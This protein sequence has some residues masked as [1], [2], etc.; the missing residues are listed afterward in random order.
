MSWSMYCCYFLYATYCLS[1]AQYHHDPQYMSDLLHDHVYPPPYHFHMCWTLNKSEKIYY[2]K[3]AG[4]W[5]LPHK[6]NTSTSTS[7]N[8]TSNTTT[9]DTVDDMYD[10]KIYNQQLQRNHER[11]SSR[12]PLPSSHQY[13][14]KTTRVAVA[15]AKYNKNKSCP[16]YHVYKEFLRKNENM[17]HLIK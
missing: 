11:L 2:L 6:K 5:Y 9:T 4:M 16:Q 17:T 7:N 15:G 14:N 10:Y 12:L 1:G 3:Q 8:T 13:K